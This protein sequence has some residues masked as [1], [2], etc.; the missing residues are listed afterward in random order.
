MGIGDLIVI[1]AV[2]LL[3]AGAVAV[4]ILK[5]KKGSSCCGS[6]SAG[7]GCGDC[8]G[9]KKDCSCEKCTGTARNDEKQRL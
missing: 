5:K 1:I 2:V 6:S 9:C 4:I 7:F 8:A 3:V